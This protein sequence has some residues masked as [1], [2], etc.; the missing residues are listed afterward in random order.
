MRISIPFAT[1]SKLSVGCQ[2]GIPASAAALL[3]KLERIASTR[4][5]NV[6]ARDQKMDRAIDI[7]LGGVLPVI[8]MVTHVVVQGHRFDIIEEVGCVPTIYVSWASL[9]L[10]S[11]PPICF[12]LVAL[13]FAGESTFYK[14]VTT[15][16]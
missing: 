3:R 16:A 11:L 6:T 4:Q 1:A 10:W 2:L 15:V 12:A 8:F 9:F 14:T 13:V 5:V 7:V